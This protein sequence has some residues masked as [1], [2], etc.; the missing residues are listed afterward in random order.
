MTLDD[1]TFRKFGK[2]AMGKGCIVDKDA[3]VGYPPVGALRSKGGK[4]GGVTRIGERCIVRSGCV[5]YATAVLKARVQLGHHVIIREG[6]SIG[7]GCRIGCFTEVAPDA[8]I[9]EGC[10][11]VGRA[12]IANGV[13]MGK[14]IFAGSGLVTAN[15]KFTTAFLNRKEDEEPMEPPVI[16]DGVLIGISVSIDPGVRV[17]KGAVIASG[18]VVTKDVPSGSIMA[19]IPGRVVGSAS[20]KLGS[21]TR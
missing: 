11:I 18:C 8:V 4:H 19:G 7:A 16:E 10:R 12:Y 1:G 6:A 15:R 20:E 5:V 13:E 21:G 9:G 2:V 14:R 3:I 17:G